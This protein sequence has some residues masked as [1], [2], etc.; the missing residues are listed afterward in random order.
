[1]EIMKRRVITKSGALREEFLL[2]IKRVVTRMRSPK[3]PRT[4]H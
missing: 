4:N 3:L 1:M 2:R